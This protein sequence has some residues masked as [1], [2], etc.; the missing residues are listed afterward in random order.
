MKNAEFLLST[1]QQLLLQEML[2]LGFTGGDPG[3]GLKWLKMYTNT[4]K[5]LAFKVMKT[6]DQTIKARSL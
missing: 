6:Y 5:V 4:Y 2:K 3:I 1:T